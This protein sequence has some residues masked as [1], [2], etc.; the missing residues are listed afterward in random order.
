MSYIIACSKLWDSAIAEKLEKR[1]PQK[2]FLITKKEDLTL[3][4]L[5]EINPTK[6]FFPHWSYILKPDIYET[7]ECVMFHM[8]DLPYGRG[9][10]PLQNLIVRGHKDTRISAFRCDGGIDTGP[11]YLKRPLNLDGTAQDIFERANAI[12]QDMIFDIITQNPTPQ[13]QSGSAV[14]F[15]R[16]TPQDGD[17]KQVQDLNTFYDYIRMLDAENYPKA[18][19]KLNNLVIEFESATLDKEE[20]IAKVR[21]RNAK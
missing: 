1:L 20:L 4:K 19:L 10:S 17:L 16:R 2:F 9:G 3:D 18:F 15:K 5:S 8:T 12:M 21:I 11:I 14:E 6:I 13:P 7:Y